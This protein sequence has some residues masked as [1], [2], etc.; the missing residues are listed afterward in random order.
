MRY[1]P[2]EPIEVWAERVSQFE[3]GLALQQIA[4]G[5]DPDV[6]LESMSA[7]IVG[8]LKYPMMKA[9][10]EWGKKS[11]DAV[12]SKQRYYQDYLSKVKPVADHMNDVPNFDDH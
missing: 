6:V 5:Q 8:K 12:A 9:I 10:K 1:D 2:N 11:Y 4:Q 3:L 7:R